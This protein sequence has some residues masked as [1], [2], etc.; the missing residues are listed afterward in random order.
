MKFFCGICMQIAEGT[1]W[2]KVILKSMERSSV[3]TSI[4]K[5]KRVVLWKVKINRGWSGGGG[6]VKYVAESGR[7]SGHRATPPSNLVR[8]KPPKSSPN[9]EC[10]LPSKLLQIQILLAS[11]QSG[12]TCIEQDTLLDAFK[13]NL[14]DPGSEKINAVPYS[15]VFRAMASGIRMRPTECLWDFGSF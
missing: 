11:P 1:A 14:N 7:D 3:E 15:L 13:S 8:S 4:R 2:G 10:S 9:P 5:A 6:W 12:P